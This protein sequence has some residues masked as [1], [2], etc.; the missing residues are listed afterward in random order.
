MG[1]FKDKWWFVAMFVPEM[2]GFKDKWWFAGMFVLEKCGF[3][4]KLD[5]EQGM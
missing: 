5:R 4:D 3:K 1:S 2:G